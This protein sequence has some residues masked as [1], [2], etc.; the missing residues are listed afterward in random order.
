MATKQEEQ[1]QSDINDRNLDL[2]TAICSAYACVQGQDCINTFAAFTIEDA[3]DQQIEVIEGKD[4]SR[5][6]NLL[7]RVER[8]KNDLLSSADEIKKLPPEAFIMTD[9]NE[10]VNTPEEPPSDEDTGLRTTETA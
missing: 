8:I 5:R 3:I 4:S 7:H 2:R 10:Q 6:P 9:A 1:R